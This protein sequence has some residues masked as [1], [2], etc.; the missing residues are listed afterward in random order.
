M[1]NAFDLPDL[2]DT[3]PEIIRPFVVLP[4]RAIEDH[5]LQPLDIRVLAI[6]CR[7]SDANGITNIGVATIAAKLKRLPKLVTLSMIRLKRRGYF[8]LLTPY[9]MGICTAS[10][11][12]IYDAPGT[13]KTAVPKAFMP[14]DAPVPL[15]GTTG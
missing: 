6:M 9:R 12:I 2:E 7:Y 13:V 3:R 14:D 11:Q 10:R 8:K 1:P 15:W 5:K 4:A